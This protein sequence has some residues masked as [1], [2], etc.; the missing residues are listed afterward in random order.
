MKKFFVIAFAIALV[1]LFACPSFAVVK[2]SKV[3]QEGK[4]L[5][6]LKGAVNVVSPEQENDEVE[7]DMDGYCRM[8]RMDMHKGWG[9]GGCCGS[10]LLRVLCGLLFLCMTSF[11]FSVIFW[12]TYKWIVFGKKPATPVKQVKTSRKR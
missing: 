1:G 3:S 12:L 6:Q 2:E 9:H 4:V 5:V 10:I 8:G 11:I 7:C